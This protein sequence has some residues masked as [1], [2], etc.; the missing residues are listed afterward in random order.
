MKT[1][2]LGDFWFEGAEA[3][4]HSLDIVAERLSEKSFP[5]VS[6]ERDV[7]PGDVLLRR[8]GTPTRCRRSCSEARRWVRSIGLRKAVKYGY[9]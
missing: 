5:T 6:R 2:G 7:S 1:G 8:E 4:M 3:G 9:S